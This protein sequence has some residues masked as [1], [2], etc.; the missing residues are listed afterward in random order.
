[1]LP[2]AE[3]ILAEEVAAPVKVRVPEVEVTVVPEPSVAAP[4]TVRA[5]APEFNVP[6]PRVTRVPP[7]VVAVPRMIESLALLM[8]TL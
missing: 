2:V 5:L 3:P 6:A 4:V 8:V 1:M 7:N